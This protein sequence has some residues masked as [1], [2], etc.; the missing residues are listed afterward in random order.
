MKHYIILRNIILF[1][2][3]IYFL[4]ISCERK[5][6]SI[7]KSINS[8]LKDTITNISE[9]DGVKM[10]KNFYT[11]YITEMSRPDLNLKKIDSLKSISCSINF[12]DYLNEEAFDYDPFI[13]AQDCDIDWLNNLTI[14]KSKENQNLYFV[15]FN[16]ND[17]DIKCIKISLKLENEEYKIDKIEEPFP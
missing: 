1:N 5:I 14:D 7:P 9:N 8:T 10:L 13:N 11:N 16:K 2:L 4:I 15:C 12:I 6:N 3:I 17:T